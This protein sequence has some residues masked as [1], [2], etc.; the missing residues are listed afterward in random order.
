MPTYEYECLDCGYHFDELQSF[1][2]DPISECPKCKGKVQKLISAGSG[3]IFKGSGFYITD[4]AKKSSP[5]PSTEPKSEKSKNSKSDKKE[6]AKP[7]CKDT[8]CCK[9]SS[10]CDVSA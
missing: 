2:D 8:P 7:C 9:D 3:L 1:S 6:A 10:R 5:E 4:Y